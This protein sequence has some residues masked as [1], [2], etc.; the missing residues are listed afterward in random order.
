MLIVHKKIIYIIS[1]V[2]FSEKRKE[3]I[4]NVFAVKPIIQQQKYKMVVK[5]ILKYKPH[6]RGLK[7][8]GN[9]SE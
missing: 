5:L 8:A 7:K 9:G 6:C 2:Y 4:S 3:T 1:I